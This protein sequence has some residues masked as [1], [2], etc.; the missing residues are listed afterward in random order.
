MAA[1]EG[2]T[3]IVNLI[4]QGVHLKTNYERQLSS[5]SHIKNKRTPATKE[6]IGF[7]YAIQISSYPQEKDAKQKVK[8][9]NNKNIEAFFLPTY[10]KGQKWFRVYVGRFETLSNA[11]KNQKQLMEQLNIKDSLIKKLPL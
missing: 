5:G 6:P 4:K 11:K 9:L 8:S 7:Q 10:I 1:Q 2:H 3:E